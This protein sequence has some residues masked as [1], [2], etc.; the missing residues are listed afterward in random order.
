M[1]LEYSTSVGA[2]DMRSAKMRSSLMFKAIILI[3]IIMITP[4]VVSAAI[5]HVP[6]DQ[7]TIQAGI[8]A[9][10]DGDTVLV[11]DGTYT[12][13]GN[14][15]IEFK[16]KAITVASENGAETCIIDCQGTEEENHRG[17]RFNNREEKDSIVSGFTIKNGSAEYGGAIAC[18]FSSPT[19]SDCILYRNTSRSHSG[20]IDCYYYAYAT[21][22]NCTFIQNSAENGS[23]GG[24]CHSFHS[25]S[26]VSHCTFIENTATAMGGGVCFVSAS[27]LIISNCS[28][29]KNAS[30]YK[31]GGLYIGNGSNY[32]IVECVFNENVS[33]EYGGGLCI[34]YGLDTTISNCAFCRNVSK[35]DGG[36]MYLQTFDDSLIF[37]SILSENLSNGHGG[38]LAC[39]SSSP[40]IVNSIFSANSAEEKGGGIFFFTT[41]MDIF[42][43]TFSGNSS[44]QGGGGITSGWFACT[45]KVHN[46]IL[47]DNYPYEIESY[48]PEPVVSYSLIQGGYPG[49]GNFDAAPLFE[50]GSPFDFH[51]QP[52][53]ICIDGGT[54]SKAPDCD[55]DGNSRPQGRAIDIGAFEYQGL[56]LVSKVYVNMPSHQFYAGDR[57][58]CSVSVWNVENTTPCD[59]R[60]FVILDIRGE[61]YCAPSFTSFDYY[62]GCF[63]NGMTEISVIPEFT[64]PSGVGSATGLVWYAALVNSEMT[65]LASEIG[66]FDFGWSE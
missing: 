50:G 53:S 31:G 27:N 1:R 18:D 46:T 66:V 59:S 60:L 48:E 23:G 56:P 2:N 26:T 4:F 38:G 16:G 36:G 30:G 19:I 13:D 32:T 21:I 62:S 47:W 10:V 34:D 65:E 33:N 35:C 24:I 6:A 29:Y 37:N 45:L 49:I 28:F 20:G 63:E 15:D 54:D 17:F 51:L 22:S 64:W 3:T 7:P 61:L 40:T 5:I 41:Q 9:A 55:F 52:T 12:G 39:E 14:R 57:S 25:K 44:K 11:A 58:S 42:N 8:D 43:C